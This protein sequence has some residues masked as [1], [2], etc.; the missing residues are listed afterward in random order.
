MKRRAGLATLATCRLICVLIAET[1]AMPTAREQQYLW[2]AA[3]RVSQRNSVVP[4]CRVPSRL[5]E[6][7]KAIQSC[8]S[9]GE[10]Q[11]A[12]LESTLSVLQSAW[13][14]TLLSV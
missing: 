5:R 1:D 11:E 7:R 2:L 14:W 8:R 9:G 4:Y 13:S 3:R 6:P 12:L 10:H